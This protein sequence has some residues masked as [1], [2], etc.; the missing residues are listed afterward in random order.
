MINA[1][2][3]VALLKDATARPALE[4]VGKSDENVRV[5]GAALEALKQRQ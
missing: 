3:G 1:A 5:R 4:H 2:R